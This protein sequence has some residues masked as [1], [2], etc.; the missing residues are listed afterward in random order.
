ML[1]LSFPFEYFLDDH[2][3]SFACPLLH[4]LFE[5]CKQ[6]YVDLVV[7]LFLLGDAVRFSKW[8]H[9]VPIFVVMQIA[10]NVG[11]IAAT[12]WTF[13]GVAFSLLVAEGRMNVV[14]VVVAGLQVLAGLESER[15][16]D[17]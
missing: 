17:I 1:L 14:S 3:Q 7:D 6:R 13:F 5:P 12:L 15:G 11:F 16:Q 10:V 4:I 8:M 9:P 2:G